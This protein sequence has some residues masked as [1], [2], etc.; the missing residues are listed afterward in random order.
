M[1]FNRF[2]YATR[3]IKFH[4]VFVGIMS[5]ISFKISFL[6]WFSNSLTSVGYII[7]EQS[8]GDIIWIFAFASEFVRPR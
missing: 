5:P 3:K 8:S 6:L 4:Y 1:E 7:E 2:I